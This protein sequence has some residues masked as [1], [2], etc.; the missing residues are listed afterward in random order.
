M[1]HVDYAHLCVWFWHTQPDDDILRSISNLL[2]Y[3]QT[4][5]ELSVY[6]KIYIIYIYIYI[7]YLHIYTMIYNVTIATCVID[8]ELN[9]KQAS[10]A[11]FF[12]LTRIKVGFFWLVASVKRCWSRLTVTDSFQESQLE[13]FLIFNEMVKPEIE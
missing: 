13:K 5:I 11:L 12:S 9:H 3:I 4:Y 10:S 2:C 8:M 7:F 1:G 6:I